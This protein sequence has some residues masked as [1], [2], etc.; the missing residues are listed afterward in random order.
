MECK[1]C[2]VCGGSV[3]S[4]EHYARQ[5][6]AALD[7][8]GMTGASFAYWDGGRLHTAV[9]GVRNSVTREPV[10]T[11]TVMHIGS[12]TKVL[13]TV[14]LMQLVD[15]GVL[16]LEDRVTQ[17]LPELRLRNGEAVERLTCGMLVNH[18]SGIDC[19]MLP[20][21]GPDRE[22]IE[23]AIE[24]C[25]GLGQL[26]PPGEG[27]S[28]C[29]MATVI[30]GY[31]TQ[32]LRGESWYTAMETRIF[33]PLDLRHAV[34]QPTDLP[35]FRC[36]VGDITD[37]VSGSSTQA[38]RPFLPLSFAPAG[39]TLMMSATDLVSFARALLAQ[40]VGPRGVRILSAASARRM[41]QPTAAL[42]H[43]AGWHW[44]LGW[45]ILPGPVLH[46][47]GGGPGVVSLLFAHPASGSAV[48]LLMNCDRNARALKQAILNPIVESWTGLAQFVPPTRVDFPVDPGIYAGVYHNNRMR[49]RVA[50]AE[51]GLLI[52]IGARGLEPNATGRLHSIGEHLFEAEFIA[53]ALPT[54]ELR[55]VQP[56]ARGRMSFLATEYR[57]LAR[58]A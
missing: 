11:D 38:K 2:S 32:K 52:Q 9:A 12:I 13:N 14:L 23:D 57:L 3:V 46:H 51:Q 42:V 56:D 45:M 4:T 1:R 37:F 34:V 18:T 47:S 22:R 41:M 17:H 28:Y 39:T 16:S 7:D 50:A 31:L 48:A 15:D 8:H 53:P 35:R 44:G 30:A 29:N 19:E 58:E 36:S 49:Y 6:N 43:P 55:F 20:D 10:T 40:G 5:L 25:A 24:R 21:H 27:P 33:E 26:H 54:T